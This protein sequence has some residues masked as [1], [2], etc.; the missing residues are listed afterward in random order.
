[1]NVQLACDSP[2]EAKSLRCTDMN[3]AIYIAL[4]IGVYHRGRKD[5][6]GQGDE[7]IDLGIVYCA[8]TIHRCFK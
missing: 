2:A 5:L 3:V 8:D 6:P 1:M 4:E 7:G